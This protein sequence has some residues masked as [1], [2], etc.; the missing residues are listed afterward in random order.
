ML[1]IS[2]AHWSLFL[3]YTTHISFWEYSYISGLV[4]NWFVTH[5]YCKPSETWFAY[6]ASL[7]PLESFSKSQ[8]ALPCSAGV[9]TPFEGLWSTGYC[10]GHPLWRKILITMKNIPL[11]ILANLTKTT[12][13]WTFWKDWRTPRE[14]HWQQFCGPWITLSASSLSL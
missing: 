8:C 4:Q 13:S 12:S 7:P 6:C 1:L 9:K 5:V 10:W 11:F 2:N 14:V 3:F